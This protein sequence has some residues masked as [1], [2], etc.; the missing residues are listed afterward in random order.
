MLKYHFRLCVSVRL[1][2]AV[3]ELLACELKSQHGP[4]NASDATSGISSSSSGEYVELTAAIHVSGYA[5]LKEVLTQAQPGSSLCCQVVGTKGPACAATLRR[6]VA[7]LLPM[8]HHSPAPAASSGTN[9]SPPPAAGSAAAGGAAGASAGGAALGLQP[10]VV[11]GAR[12]AMQDCY[13]ALARCAADSGAR[14]G[15]QGL[16]VCSCTGRGQQLYAAP[17]DPAAFG[18]VCEARI[19]DGVAGGSVPFVGVYVSGELGPEVQ[20]M[21]T[22][23][24]RP[25]GGEGGGEAAIAEMQ[26]FTS[27]VAA[28]G[29][30]PGVA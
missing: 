19:I 28:W 21:S 16:A 2:V 29:C 6:S 20:H 11:G 26:G 3:C 18:E 17:G 30:Q 12:R 5:A 14:S 24:G 15:L 25:G 23:W 7:Q 10:A 22:G 1:Q 9:G 27:M 13:D 4:T 8:V